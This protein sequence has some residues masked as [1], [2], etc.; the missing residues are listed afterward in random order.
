MVKR[1]IQGEKGGLHRGFTLIEVMV[2]IILIG[3]ILLFAI[4]NFASIQ[5]RARIR[6]GAQEI[7]Q[8]L[9]SVRERALASGQNFYAVKDGS[10]KSYHVYL[11]DG[12]QQTRNL[13]ATTGGNLRFGTTNAGTGI[14]E[15]P[16]GMVGSFDFVTGDTLWFL[17]R[18]SMSRGA[19]YLTDGKDDYAVGVTSLGMIRV[20]AW[21]KTGTWN[22]F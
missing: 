7:G 10:N 20:Y 18:G 15:D 11:P 21:G 12:S 22:K 9:R 6:A 2:I 8:D 3:I 5:R 1:F 19:I 14:P 16:D 13:G 17:P 4:P